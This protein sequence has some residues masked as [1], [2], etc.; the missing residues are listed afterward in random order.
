MRFR[1][2]KRKRWDFGNRE[3]LKMGRVTERFDVEGQEIEGIS[4][5]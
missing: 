4:F 1:K 3:G 5:L 2:Y